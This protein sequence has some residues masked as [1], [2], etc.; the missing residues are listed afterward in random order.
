MKRSI[1]IISLSVAIGAFSYAAWAGGPQHIHRYESNLPDPAAIE[2]AKT[3]E[4]QA[5]LAD[6]CEAEAVTLHKMAELHK[7]MAETY[8]QPGGKPWMAAQAKHCS[9]VAAK[10]EEAAKEELA[11]AAV[12]R[13]LPTSRAGK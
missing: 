13:N 7:S 4:D 2:A 12:H 1:V 10:L 9:S 3:P 6:A 11:I 5:A 8:A